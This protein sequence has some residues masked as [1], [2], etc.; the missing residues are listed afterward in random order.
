[1]K[2]QALNKDD[3]KEL[4]AIALL[5]VVSALVP[6]TIGITLPIIGNVICSASS[7]KAYNCEMRELKQRIE[8]LGSTVQE[9]IKKEL[10]RVG[11]LVSQTYS[12]EENYHLPGEVYSIDAVEVIFRTELDHDIIENIQQSLNYYIK[13]GIAYDELTLDNDD[14]NCPVDIVYTTQNGAVFNLLV[15]VTRDDVQELLADVDR[16]IQLEDCDNQIKRVILY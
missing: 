10:M 7:K 8:H 14:T 4:S 13:G 2:K 12:K 1:M 3:W 16:I 15:S 9:E 6:G 5:D 11:E